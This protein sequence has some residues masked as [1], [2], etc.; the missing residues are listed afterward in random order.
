MLL[1]VNAA[2]TQTRVEKKVASKATGFGVTYS[3]PKTTFVITVE[4]TK[5]ACKAG[6]YYKYADLLLGIKNAVMEDN[7]SYELGK[8][9]MV[10]K[11]VPDTE[12]TYVVEFKSGTVAPYVYLTTDGLLCAINTEYVPTDSKPNTDPVVLQSFDLN[13]TT[14][15]T[16]EFLKAGTVARQAEV[17]AQQIYHIRERKMDILTGDAENLPPDGEAMRLVIQGLEDQ[18]QKLTSLFAGG[19]S[20]ETSYHV[21]TLVP[22]ENIREQV[23][24]R[25]SNRLGLLDADDLGG[26]PVYFT[27][28][29]TE[30]AQL[31]D[32]KE[33][34]KK[35]KAMKG[36][37]YNLPGKARVEI[38]TMQ[39]PLFT[40]EMQ[41]VQF[42][43]QESLAPVMF[44]DKKSPVKVTFYPE[45]GAIRQITQ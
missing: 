15:Y 14:V 45:T 6:P 19:C 34:E 10:N 16:E 2:L 44:E 28:Q 22:E 13:A 9:T 33:A 29:V 32:P 17:A 39:N 43:T 27:L 5:T 38:K 25:F 26:E 23:L 41:V 12:N 18:E 1:S 11:G 21:I 42:G 31:L 3:L 20:K 8:V 40:G 7:V 30:R 35:A 36:I 24:F 4:I 37:I